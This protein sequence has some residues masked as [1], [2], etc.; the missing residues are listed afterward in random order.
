MRGR[1]GW[2]ENEKSIVEISHIE[3][4]LK[5]DHIDYKFTITYRDDNNPSLLTTM[6]LMTS[7]FTDYFSVLP[8]QEY[9]PVSDG[10]ESA[11][12]DVLFLAM[13]NNVKETLTGKDLKNITNIS[14]TVSENSQSVRFQLNYVDHLGLLLSSEHEMSLTKEIDERI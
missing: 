9:N 13:L 10:T 6:N 8:E 12:S 11:A 5:P 3:T 4:F 14:N 1:R 2:V 7:T